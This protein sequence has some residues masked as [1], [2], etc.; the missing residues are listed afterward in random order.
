MSS[1]YGRSRSKVVELLAWIFDYNTGTK[2]KGSKMLTL[3]WSDGAIFLLLDFIYTVKVNTLS[4]GRELLVNRLNV[5][6]LPVLCQSALEVLL[7]S[8]YNTPLQTNLWVMSG[9]GKLPSV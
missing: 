3:G 4:L 1:T 6:T 7:F 2:L 8:F 9:T 5:L